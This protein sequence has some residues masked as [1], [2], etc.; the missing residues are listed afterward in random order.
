MIKFYSG[1]YIFLGQVYL[2]PNALVDIIYK[3]SI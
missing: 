3:W 2:P 1:L